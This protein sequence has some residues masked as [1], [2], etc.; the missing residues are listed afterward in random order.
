MINEAC[1]YAMQSHCVFTYLVIYVDTLLPFNFKLLIVDV[2]YIDLRCFPHVH[3][4][5]SFLIHV[6]SC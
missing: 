5:I 2:V 3:K 4:L 1:K 6:L